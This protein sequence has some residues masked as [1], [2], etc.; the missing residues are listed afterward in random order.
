MDRSCACRFALLSNPALTVSVWTRLWQ[1]ESSL[2]TVGATSPLKAFLICAGILAFASAIV[3]PAIYAVAAVAFALSFT[4]FTS[5]AVW[6]VFFAM[7][8]GIGGALTAVFGSLALF[9]VGPLAMTFFGFW[10][11]YRIGRAVL[12][13]GGDSGRRQRS[14]R[15]AV[16][17][18][19]AP[20]E[21]GE[22]RRVEDA[23]DERRR[24]EI[25]D[26]LRAFDTLLD[27]RDKHRK[28][29]L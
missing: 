15:R 4:A 22:A 12:G 20:E 26:E 16:G 5:M 25:E 18:R 28:D 27:T 14:E 1:V 8:I 2:S 23:E 11:V 7:A 19:A 21:K 24:R 9:A 13:S 6:G 10:L 17:Q 29:F 3:G